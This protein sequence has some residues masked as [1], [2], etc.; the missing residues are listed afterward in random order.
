MRFSKVIYLIMWALL[1]SSCTAIKRT[2]YLQDVQDNAAVNVASEQ[3]IRIKP[4]DRLTVVVSSKDPELAAPFNVMTSYNSL[5]NNPIGQTSVTSSSGLQVRT[6][7]AKGDLYMPIIGT[8]HCEGMTRTE[9][10]DQIAKRII[11]GGYIADAAVNIQFADMKVFVMGEV[12][13]PGQFDVTRDQITI[14]EA[15]A[16]AGD[17]TIYGNR[18]NVTVVRKESG[19]T[20]T[21]RLNLLDA[22]CFASPAYYLQQGDV[23]YVQPKKQRAAT[24][25]INQNRSFWISIASTLLSAASLVMTIINYTQR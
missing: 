2:A 8:L 16:M 15:L 18:E 7:D 24:G 23:V 25:E 4:Y 3:Q 10:A 6:V 14:L 13:R 17:M 12:A 1:L 21:Y 22:Q 19:Q 11:D 9:L 20:K 5:S